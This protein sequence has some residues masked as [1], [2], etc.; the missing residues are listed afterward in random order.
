MRT[1]ITIRD[2]LLAEAQKLSGKSGFSEAIV[3]SLEDYVA[4]RKRLALLDDLFDHKTPHS[5]RRVK[6]MRRMGSGQTS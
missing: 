1:T 6:S 3:S 4:L 5:Q 2:E